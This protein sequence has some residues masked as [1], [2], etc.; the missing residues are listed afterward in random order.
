MRFYCCLLRRI[1][2]WNCLGVRTGRSKGERMRHTV[3]ILGG[4]GFAVSGALYGAT[5]DKQSF[6]TR[7]KS[8]L[9]QVVKP[10][11]PGLAIC[12]ASEGVISNLAASGL[13]RLEDKTPMTVD[14]PVYIAS[15]AKG[16]T[17]VAILKLV[18]EKRLS[19][20]ER[21]T[22]RLPTLPAYMAPV[23]VRHLLTHTAG[24]PD[25]EDS[26]GSK[27]GLTNAEVMSN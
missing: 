19:L 12:V 22:E 4:L 25:H 16:F 14:T 7:L 5:A 3:A 20:D 18:E 1:L 15:L 24:V 6:Q 27:S 2:A 23:T 26:L 13:A 8:E 21:V 9:Q 17:T 11:E 10:G